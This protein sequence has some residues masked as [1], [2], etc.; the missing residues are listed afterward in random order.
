[1]SWIVIFAA[2]VIPILPL[3]LLVLGEYL[4]RPAEPV[5]IP[6]GHRRDG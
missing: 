1:M 5:C 3:S 2:F 4:Q 6:S